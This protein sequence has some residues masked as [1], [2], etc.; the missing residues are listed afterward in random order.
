M[1]PRLQA[2]KLCLF[3]TLMHLFLG[4]AAHQTRFKR[5]PKKNLV[6]IEEI[7]ELLSEQP[8]E[9]DRA[10]YEEIGIADFFVRLKSLVNDETVTI[11]GIEIQNLHTRLGAMEPL[12]SSDDL[13][14]VS[15]GELLEDSGIE[16]AS[17]IETPDPSTLHAL[18]EQTQDIVEGRGPSGELLNFLSDTAANVAIEPSELELLSL[19]EETKT[20]TAEFCTLFSA[21]SGVVA[22]AYEAFGQDAYKQLGSACIISAKEIITGRGS[23]VQA[24]IEAATPTVDHNSLAGR[25][26]LVKASICASYGATLLLN[27]YAMSLGKTYCLNQAIEDLTGINPA[28][29]KKEDLQKIIRNFP[30]GAN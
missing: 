4:C 28:K 5:S 24:D 22:T 3:L 29:Q 7:K 20:R 15:F 30:D 6:E 23:V 26:T 19:L 18:M 16:T 10:R 2:R 25:S 13:A 14:S 8:S 21:Y 17:T 11:Q 27:A 1:K 9:D 12:Y